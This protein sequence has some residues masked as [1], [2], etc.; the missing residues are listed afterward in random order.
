MAF[1]ATLGALTEE[2]VEVITSTS[3]QVGIEVNCITQSS[4]LTLQ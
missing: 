3:S 4:T 1:A 2:L